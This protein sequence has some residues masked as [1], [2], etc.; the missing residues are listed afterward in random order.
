M[1]YSKQHEFPTHG[2]CA[3]FR[4]GY[5]SVYGIAVDPDSP[6]CLNFTPKSIITMPQRARAYPET[7]QLYETYGPRIQS[8]RSRML[9]Y[10]PQTGYSFSFPR[11]RQAQTQYDY[12]K[13]YSSPQVPSVAAPIPSGIRFALISSRVKSRLGAA[14]GGRGGSGR[15]R[16]GGFAAGP[17][18]NC[19]CPNCG[20]TI[21]HVRGIPCFQQTCPKCGS[22][23]TRGA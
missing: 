20:Y 2:D 11:I 3:N 15:G 4:S 21:S 5:C 12:Y 7:K 14:R 13:R 8:Y 18:G 19:I 23:M 17:S 10:Q 9:P 16:T 6:A 22:R 1:V